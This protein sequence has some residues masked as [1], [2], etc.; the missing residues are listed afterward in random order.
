MGDPQYDQRS[1]QLQQRRPPSPSSCMSC[2]SLKSPQ[3]YFLF[4]KQHPFVLGDTTATLRPDRRT[5]DHSN[6]L[7]GISTGIKA[8]WSTYV[9]ARSAFWSERGERLFSNLVWL[10]VGHRIEEGGSCS[11][12]EP[13]GGEREL[14]QRAMTRLPQARS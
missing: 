10:G 3:R 13:K 8:G 14:N 9:E 4:L 12:S 1:R 5:D 2:V 7:M 6:I 11:N